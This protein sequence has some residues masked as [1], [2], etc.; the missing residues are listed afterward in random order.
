MLID[1]KVLRNLSYGVYIVGTKNV[2]CV[3]NTAV[4]I[5]S[6]PM[7]I[8]I[9]I[10]HDNYTN[11]SI[12]S[13]GKFTLSILK[14]NT[15]PEIIGTFGYSSSKN[16]DK[17]STVECNMVENFPVIK[18]SC[19]NLLCEVINQIECESHTIFIGKVLVSTNY[20][21]DKPMTYQYYQSVLKGKSPKN[22]PTYVE[23]KTK[24]KGWKCSVC[25]YV[26]E[27]E[28]LPENYICPICGQP[29]TVFRKIE[30]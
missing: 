26:Y 28:T 2:G 12:K 10:H 22:A 16:V 24:I 17:F 21:E 29:H 20:T 11:E 13:C 18:D 1:K 6:D 3:I 4:Q 25:G 30:E 7:I 14:E 19:G 27:G 9:S 15:N 5:T 8:A 23:E